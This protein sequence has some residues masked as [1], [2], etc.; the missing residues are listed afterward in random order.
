V[1]LSGTCEGRSHLAK[2]FLAPCFNTGL[3]FARAAQKIKKNAH[4]K[5]D[6]GAAPKMA[7]I[8]ATLNFRGDAERMR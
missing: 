1:I 6:F 5:N 8:K 7:P 4:P 2:S 3:T